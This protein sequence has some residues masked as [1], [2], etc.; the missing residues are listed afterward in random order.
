[1]R[2]PNEEPQ[3]P[4]SS[5]K[6]PELDP[7]QEQLFRE[8]LTLLNESGVPYVVSGAFA[9]RVHT[10]I[11]RDTKDL[12][13]F[14]P[15]ES[16]GEAMKFLR[17]HGFECKVADPVWLAKAHRGDF[18]VDMI[19][20]MSTGTITVD[21]TWIERGLL[22]ELFGVKVKMLGPEEL[23]ASKLFV[24]RRERFDGAD[25]AHVIYGT[26]GKLDWDRVYQLVGEHWR[27]LFWHLVLY[28][29]VYPAH[30]DFVPKDVWRDL[31]GRFREE[32]EHVERNAEFRGSLIDPLMFAI[33]VEEWGLADL[34]T[35]YREEREPKLPELCKTDASLPPTELPKSA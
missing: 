1:V 6:P 23:I 32:V 4:V 29:Y 25:I 8:V 20:G 11:C 16:V 26:H 34:H 27:L 15:P 33:D 17:Q 30:A 12:D 24:T 18:F 5:S 22:S 14:L 3:L 21:R 19:T 7:E 31:M 13:L 2:V 35:Q 9:L 10:G 28:Q